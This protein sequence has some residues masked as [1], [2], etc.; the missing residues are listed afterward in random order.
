VQ[1]VQLAI[2]RVMAEAS[3]RLPDDGRQVLTADDVCAL[4]GVS[5][6]TF[7]RLQR[8]GDLSPR[9][10]PNGPPRFSRAVIEQWLNTAPARRRAS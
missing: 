3:F 2:L 8:R 5:R 4:L 10:L 9:L 7:E 6:R 1:V